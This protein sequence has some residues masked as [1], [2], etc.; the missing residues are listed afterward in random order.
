MTDITQN[1]AKRSI[2]TIIYNDK[3]LKALNTIK[4]AVTQVTKRNQP[5]F[6]KKFILIT[7]ASETDMGA[8]LA[9]IDKDL[10]EKM[11]IIFSKNFEKHQLNYSVIAKEL[12]IV[13]GIAHFRHYLARK[14]F[15]LRTYHKALESLWKT[16]N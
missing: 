10:V 2:D 1:E 14:P 11:I 5:D 6:S 13:K 8:I 3:S 9:Q 12:C 15:L 16:R 4:I 7:D